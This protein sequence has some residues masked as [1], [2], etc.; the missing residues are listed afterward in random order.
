MPLHKK[1]KILRPAKEK[2]SKPQIT[3]SKFAGRVTKFQNFYLY[4]TKESLYI[5]LLSKLPFLTVY[6]TDG[7]FGMNGTTSVPK[8]I[9]NS[10][11]HRLI[12]F[13][14]ASLY[15]YSQAKKS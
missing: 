2:K 15:Q 8:S 7:V 11:C 14:I 1:K 5:V 12:A 6:V 10:I 3:N 9:F 4:R 13:L